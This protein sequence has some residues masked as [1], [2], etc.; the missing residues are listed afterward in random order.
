MAR[1]RI[2]RSGRRSSGATKNQLW[3]PTIMDEVTVNSS[4]V[5]VVLCNGTDWAIGGGFEKATILRVRGWL[6][7]TLDPLNT[8]AGGIAMMIYHVDE[9]DTGVSPIA[10]VVYTD[11]DVLWTQGFAW[12]A[13]N[14]GAVEARRGY[15]FNVDVKSMRKTNNGSDLRLSLDSFNAS[16]GSAMTGVLR[17]LLRKS[18]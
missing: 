12:G 1:R 18:G 13:G 4:G 9:D 7:F 10:A 14:A 6:S 3:I 2:A 5:E 16:Q 8:V 15:H 17:V 11:E